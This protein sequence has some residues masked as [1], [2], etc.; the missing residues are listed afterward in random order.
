[1]RW[2]K[3]Q[4]NYWLPNKEQARMTNTSL[5]HMQRARMKKRDKIVAKLNNW[6]EMSELA[7]PKQSQVTHLIERFGGLLP[8]SIAVGVHPEAIIN[9]WLAYE[10]EGYMPN[11]KRRKYYITH[12][13]I[14]PRYLTRLLVV[15]RY[16]GVLIRPED[17]YPDYI[18][19][20][21]VKNY[22]GNEEIMQWIK[23]I[24]NSKDQKQ[25]EHIIASLVLTPD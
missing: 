17:L 12:G 11:E 4:Q 14:P 5:R 9:N 16:W 10:I 20:N 3:W 7:T 22:H 25:F 21:I 24:G 13:V 23:H 1:M 6:I 15:A 18:E 19:N 8:F 2:E